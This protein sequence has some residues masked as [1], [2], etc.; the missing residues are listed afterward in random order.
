MKEYRDFY[1]KAVEAADSLF[2]DVAGQTVESCTSLVFLETEE[3]FLTNISKNG[4]Y[5]L[6]TFTRILCALLSN[7][8][9]ELASGHPESNNIDKNTRISMARKA[10]ISV[11]VM[12]EAQRDNGDY[13]TDT[14]VEHGVQ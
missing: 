3:R 13:D 9:E 10:I 6:V 14:E 12:R 1:K 5:N 2:D 11:I 8:S 4:R 7:F